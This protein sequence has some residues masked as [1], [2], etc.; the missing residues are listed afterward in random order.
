MIMRWCNVQT[1][2]YDHQ[3]IMYSI[4]N[5]NLLYQQDSTFISQQPGDETS[6]DIQMTKFDFVICLRR[7]F[8]SLGPSDAIW[9][10]RS[11]STLAQVMACSLTVPS[12]YLNQCWLI[13]TKVEWH[14]SKGK[15]RRDTSAINHWNYLENEVPKFHSNFPGRCGNK[16]LIWLHFFSS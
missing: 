14:S 2:G 7:L 16:F 13:I 4:Y 1:N 3:A 11:G 8:N 6:A 12:H 10:Q 9:R 15:F 5:K